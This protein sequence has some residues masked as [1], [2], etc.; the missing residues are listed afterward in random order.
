MSVYLALC[1]VW[2]MVMDGDFT[3]SV[4]L[5]EIMVWEDL[6]FSILALYLLDFEMHMRVLHGLH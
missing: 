1:H 2:Y 3:P 5:L 6:D 4:P